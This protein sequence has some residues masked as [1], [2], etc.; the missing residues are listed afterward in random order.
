AHVHVELVFAKDLARVREDVARL[1]ADRDNPGLG[2]AIL[3]HGPERCPFKGGVEGEL[4]DAPPGERSCHPARTNVEPA[5]VEPFK[6]RLSSGFSAGLGELREPTQG[7]I[8]GSAS[9]H[10]RPKREE[11]PDQASN[12]EPTTQG[13]DP[14]PY[15]SRA[16]SGKKTAILRGPRS[17]AQGFEGP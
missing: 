7:R 14:G 3:V 8:Y 6:A 13:H 9:A 4:G 10:D 17:P 11:H 16:L 2:N 5:Q 1:H 12:A 15:R